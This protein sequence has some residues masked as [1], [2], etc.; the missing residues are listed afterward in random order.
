MK[1][2][3]NNN[4]IYVL[5]IVLLTV[6]LYPKFP[7]FFLPKTSVAVRL[8]DFVIL[9]A[10]LLFLIA[11]MTNI[12]TILKN[13]IVL[14]I[15]LFFF[16]ALASVLSGAYLT[17][18]LTLQVG[19]LHLFR[20]VEYISL[21][22]M[23]MFSIKT[24]ENLSFLVK[25][26]LLTFIYA[27]IYGFAQKYYGLPIITTQNSEY[28]KGAALLYRD[29]SHLVST[30]AGHYDMASYILFLSPMLYL[31][32]FANRDTYK[33]IF[34]ET[35]PYFARTFVVLTI[36]AGLWLL[37]NAASRISIVSYM[38][39]VFLALV[40]IRKFIY[41]PIVFFFI[42]L[43]VNSAGNLLSRYSTI[44]EVVLDKI[45]TTEVITE[46]FAQSETTRPTPTPTPVPV[47]EDRSTSIRTAVEWPRALRA[48]RK[49]PIFGTGYSS[50]TLAT[51][52]DY[53]RMLGESGIYGFLSF[54]LAL[55][56]ILLELSKKALQSKWDSL[57]G[58]FIVGIILALPGVLLNMVFIDILEASKFA[59]VFWLLLGAAT[60]VSK[61]EK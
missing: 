38:G 60:G 11:N 15:V 37:V 53:L 28:A 33:R 14:S 16:I 13:K 1:K 5:G 6:P 44:F 19:L 52:N 3:I 59:I 39:G 17:K 34:G 51:D 9:S 54:F 50:I 56:F 10:G 32:L 58:M 4:M 55:A 12:L 31:L 27:F 22:V 40:A 23:S 8:E 41:I 57:E 29:G 36:T 42:I 24:R 49:N 46:A 48:L 35:H 18:T 20:R 21:F 47:F 7:L 25:V 61:Y 30:F 45:S 26:T 2:L 43:F